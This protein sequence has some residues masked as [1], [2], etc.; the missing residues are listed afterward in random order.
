ML[1][2]R[3]P[4]R[5]FIKTIQA[6]LSYTCTCLSCHR[7]VCMSWLVCHI[8]YGFLYTYVGYVLKL[9]LYCLHT[10]IFCI[11]YIHMH[12]C[13]LCSH[14]HRKCALLSTTAIYCFYM[15]AYACQMSL[16]SP[17]C[18]PQGT[19]AHIQSTTSTCAHQEEDHSG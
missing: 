7:C 6:C 8:L 16:S 18:Q 1:Y 11:L 13:A 4:W 9:Y 17:Q 12:A 10:H 14:S 19:W 2:S 3:F 15:W 5:K